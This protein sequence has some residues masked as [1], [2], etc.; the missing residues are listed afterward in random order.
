VGSKL[1]FF[2]PL[3]GQSL[4]LKWLYDEGHEVVGVELSELAVRTYFEKHFAGSFDERPVPGVDGKLFATADGRLR[5]YQ[6]DLFHFGPSL[7]QSFNAVFDR[8]SFIAINFADHQRYCSLLSSICAPGCRS[9]LES[10]VFDP[11]LWGGPPHSVPA[12]RVH[13]I[14]EPEW[15]V[16]RV[17]EMT[18]DAILELRLKVPVQLKDAYYEAQYYLL[19]RSA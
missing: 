10:W 19:E 6:M 17:D 2:L 9:L 13:S 12:E 7:E 15:R 11:T 4:D 5:I 8:G 1:K 14:F 3:C 16:E 18:R